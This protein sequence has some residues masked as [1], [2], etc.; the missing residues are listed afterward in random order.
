LFHERYLIEK[1]ARPLPIGGS[2][3]RLEQLSW[4][5]RMQGQPFGGTT[6]PEATHWPLPLQVAGDGYITCDYRVRWSLLRGSF[7]DLDT[8]AQDLS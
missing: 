6:V 7:L 3:Y 5:R 1:F 4:N 2:G 8:A